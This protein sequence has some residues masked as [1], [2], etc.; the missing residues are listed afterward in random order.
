MFF[1]LPSFTGFASSYL[2]LPNVFPRYSNM[3]VTRKELSVKIGKKS[4]RTSRKWGE[5][6][7]RKAEKSRE[8]FILSSI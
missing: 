7:Y 5:A 6:V 4:G 1:D 2:V 3:K 8:K